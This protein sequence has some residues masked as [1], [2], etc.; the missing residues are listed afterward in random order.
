MEGCLGCICY[1]MKG[2]AIFQKVSP[3]I[4]GRDVAE[5]CVF[6]NELPCSR[7]AGYLF[8]IPALVAFG[9]AGGR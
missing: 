5:L 7:T 1:F 8:V 2:S 4:S 3:T 9:A 6:S